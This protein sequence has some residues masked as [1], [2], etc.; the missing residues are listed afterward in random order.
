MI[1]RLFF[2]AIAPLVLAAAPVCQDVASFAWLS[3]EWLAEEGGRWTV[4]RWSA[5]RGGVMLGT[6]LSGR[7]G[8]AD[9]YEYMRIAEDGEGIAFFASPQ[10]QPAVRFAL[11]SSRPG[12]AAFENPANDYPVRIVYRRSGALLVAT[13]SGRGGA[14]TQ[15]WRYRLVRPGR[16]PARRAR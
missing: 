16:P 1:A 7:G 12:E 8:R 14:N 10:G 5:P 15:T 6:S 3:G 13:I 11:V 4:E 9:A 2:V